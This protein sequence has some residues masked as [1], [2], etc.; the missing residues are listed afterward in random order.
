MLGSIRRYMRVR[1]SLQTY[2]FWVGKSIAPL[3]TRWDLSSHDQNTPGVNVHSFWAQ[4]Y[5]NLRAARARVARRYDAN[6]TPHKYKLGDLVMYKRNLVS[7]KA[8]NVSGKLLMRWS[9]PVVVA[10]YVGP[11]SVLLANPDTGVIIRRAHVSQLKT[12]VS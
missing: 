11:N 6:R 8:R 1:S 12:Y 2:Y 3:S 9:D 10:K 5:A 4:A 7:S